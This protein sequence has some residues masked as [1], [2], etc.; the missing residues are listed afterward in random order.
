MSDVKKFRN[1]QDKFG[2]ET[3]K[4]KKLISENSDWEEYVD[5]GSIEPIKLLIETGSFKAVESEYN[6]NYQSLR[7]K[8]M[9]AS[10]RIENKNRVGL[11]GAQSDKAK[12]LKKLLSIIPD[13]E[14]QKILS[15]T[16]Y[17]YA[18][19]YLEVE[20]FNEVGRYF[21]AAPANV[22]KALYGDKTRQGALGKME[23]NFYAL[24][25]VE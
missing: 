6:I 16:E 4:L 24:I 1:C 15:A 7:G 11:R 12:K 23:K 18:I 22:A 8:I 14:L 20:N 17:K 19:K 3:N 25:N 2:A 9:R 10:K 5:A 13:S 21:S